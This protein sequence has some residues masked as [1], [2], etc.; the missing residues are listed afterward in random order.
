MFRAENSGT[1]VEEGP[2]FF[3]DLGGAGFDAF[4]LDFLASCSSSSFLEVRLE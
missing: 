3:A 4:A 2:A 1:T